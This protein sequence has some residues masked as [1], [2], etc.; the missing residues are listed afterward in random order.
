MVAFDS[1]RAMVVLLAKHTTQARNL[2][3]TG[4][5]GSRAT[6]SRSTT[7]GNMV[8][9]ASIPVERGAATVHLPAKSIATVETA[10]AIGYAGL[11]RWTAL[12]VG[13]AGVAQSMCAKLEGAE[14]AARRGNDR[15]RDALPD[16]YQ[17][18]APGGRPARQAPAGRTS[19]RPDRPRGGPA[20]VR[21]VMP[22]D[23]G[24][25]GLRRGGR[26]RHWGWGRHEGRPVSCGPRDMVQEGY[27]E[28]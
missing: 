8:P 19:R 1:P 11:C 4:L 28:T 12:Y 7:S 10:V 17:H 25:G 2:A 9:A 13:D 5:T 26:G 27:D 24:V 6:V 23:A 14:V 18:Q 16:A 21:R 15:A 20:P 22:W 3:L